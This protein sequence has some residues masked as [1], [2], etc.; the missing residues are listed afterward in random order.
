M[1]NET[2]P[3]PAEGMTEFHVEKRIAEL[4][5]GVLVP[6]V[7]PDEY[8]EAWITSREAPGPPL[9]Q[10]SRAETGLAPAS[11]DQWAPGFLCSRTR[12]HPRAPTPGGAARP[13]RG[14]RTT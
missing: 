14:R 12:R 6:L 5:A 3:A 11:S 8:R 10:R 7:L 13:V 2:L 9:R 4:A 1:S